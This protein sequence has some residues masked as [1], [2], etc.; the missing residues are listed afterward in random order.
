MFWNIFHSFFSPIIVFFL[1]SKNIHAASAPGV[2][3]SPF[4]LSD[5]HHRPVPSSFL[6]FFCWFSA[7]RTCG[8]AFRI[9]EIDGTMT[10]GTS[11]R[12]TGLDGDRTSF[13]P[14]DFP[15]DEDVCHLPACR[16]DDYAECLT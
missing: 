9:R 2:D 14:K 15:V 10:A 13:D 4:D 6:N 1:S 11:C 7:A 8:S 16:F 3:G 5:R 12:F